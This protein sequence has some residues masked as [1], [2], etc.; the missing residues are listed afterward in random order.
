MGKSSLLAR[1]VVW[2]VGFSALLGT[3]SR[4]IAQVKD[5]R[6]VSVAEATGM[7]GQYRGN[8]VMFHIYA[9]WC[10]PCRNEF[11]EILRLDRDYR[12]RGFILLPFSKDY[13]RV[14]LAGWLEDNKLP[15]TAM[16]F[17]ETDPY[18]LQNTIK[19][20]GGS[21]SGTIPYTMIIDRSGR[22][23]KDWV[24]GYDYETFRRAIEPLLAPAGAAPVAGPAGN[25]RP[26]SNLNFSLREYSVFKFAKKQTN[27]YVLAPGGQTSAADAPMFMAGS[28]YSKSAVT[29]RKRFAEERLRT[30]GAVTN[31]AVVSGK[32]V[33]INGTPGFEILATAFDTD[34]KKTIVI[35]QTILFAESSYF[36]MQGFTKP[37]DQEEH[38]QAF[39]A[40]VASFHRD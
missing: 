8:V 6:D 24:G 27:M 10:A 40:I 19:R 33:V 21:Y 15:T 4:S 28:A 12:G 17:D 34:L 20:Y 9:S 2:M 31:V 37:G 36:I 13:N 22:F 11:P 1:T 16:R 29:D 35:F 14:A 18:E 7:I 38:V 5:V 30:T 23:V 25:T 39:R 32:D 26:Y 3:G